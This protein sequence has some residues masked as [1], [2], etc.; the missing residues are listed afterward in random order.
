MLLL[1]TFVSVPLLFSETVAGGGGIGGFRLPI[2]SDKGTCI[3]I[4]P[5]YQCF[6]LSPSR[7]P[8][9]SLLI[10]QSAQHM[11]PAVPS[12]SPFRKKNKC[13]LAAPFGDNEKTF[14]GS[15][16]GVPRFREFSV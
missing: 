12:P 13:I 15:H 3:H 1:P 10:R 4:L 11:F 16:K 6:P 5:L 14:W 9:H 7:S 8:S 2:L